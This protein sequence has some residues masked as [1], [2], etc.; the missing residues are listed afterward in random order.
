METSFKSEKKRLPK[1]FLSSHD[2]PTFNAVEMFYY[3]LISLPK[4]WN[5]K[6][7]N[8]ESVKY[9]QKHFGVDYGFGVMIN[10]GIQHGCCKSKTSSG[11][12]SAMSKAYIQALSLIGS[13]IVHK[14]A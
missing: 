1:G 12:H 7:L 4:G 2:E 5:Q 10:W 11:R 6:V 13:G 8:M 3:Y 9:V 14:A